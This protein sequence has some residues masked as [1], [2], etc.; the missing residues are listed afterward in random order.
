MRRLQQAKHDP[1]VVETTITLYDI[2][3]TAFKKLRNAIHRLG[4]SPNNAR[5]HEIRIKTKRARYAAQLAEP[6]VGKAATRFIK[7]AGAVQDVLGM[8]QDAIQAEAHVRAFL[9]QSTSVR[10]A[11]VAGRNANENDANRRER[12]C[13]RFGEDY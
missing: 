2:A 3:K 1:I 13:D 4:S 9:K 8:H 5:L 11:F 12:T 10:A 6:T 7:S